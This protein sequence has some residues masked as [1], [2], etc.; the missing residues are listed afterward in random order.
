[1]DQP[2]C[3]IAL[4]MGKCTLANTAEI[5][6]KKLEIIWA[7]ENLL[8]KQKILTIRTVAHQYVFACELSN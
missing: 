3:P 6:V 5:K 7:K 2:M 4:S 8:T 1:M